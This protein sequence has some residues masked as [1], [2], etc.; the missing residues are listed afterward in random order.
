MR[1]GVVVSGKRFLI[2]GTL[3]LVLIGVLGLGWVMAVE[4]QAADP[5]FWGTPTP[6]PR[7]GVLPFGG[8]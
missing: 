2:T 1:D 4:P 5:A 7:D 8:R 3:L 6:Q